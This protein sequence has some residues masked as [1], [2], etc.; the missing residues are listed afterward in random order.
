ME[1]IKSLLVSI[2]KKLDLICDELFIDTKEPEEPIEDEIMNFLNS[3]TKEL[4]IEDKVK[5]CKV[6]CK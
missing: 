3:I 1:D 5:I 2:D 4:N 6:E